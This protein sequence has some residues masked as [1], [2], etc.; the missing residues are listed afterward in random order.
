[1]QKPPDTYG[2]YRMSGTELPVVGS[3][4][5]GRATREPKVAKILQ[6]FRR[7]KRGKIRK[8]LQMFTPNRHRKILQMFRRNKH[9]KIRRKAVY[10]AFKRV[11]AAEVIQ[12]P[13]RRKPFRVYH[14]SR[15]VEELPDYETVTRWLR[16][17]DELLGSADSD[18]DDYQDWDDR[19]R[20]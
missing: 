9:H 5:D 20:A 1:M 7:K 19:R 2:E 11:L 8:I 13:R 3:I 12:F 10:S 16:L 17:A 18:S 15:R 14:H 6:M 4:L